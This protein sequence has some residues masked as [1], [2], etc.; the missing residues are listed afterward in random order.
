[1]C[2]DEVDVIGNRAI[3]ASATFDAGQAGQVDGYAYQYLTAVFEKPLAR[4]TAT[5]DAA[6]G[7]TDR[8]LVVSAKASRGLTQFRRLNQP[9]AWLERMT[10]GLEPF[11]LLVPRIETGAPANIC[12]ADLAATWEVGDAGYESRSINNA[13]GGRT[14]T[15]QDTRPVGV[16]WMGRP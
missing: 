2:T 14:L 12:L 11:G 5:L 16:A 7:K 4:P 8:K 15:G 13:F 10:S 6:V 9:E 3:N 1:M